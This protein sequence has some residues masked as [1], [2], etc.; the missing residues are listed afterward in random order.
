MR[1]MEMITDERYG[2]AFGEAAHARQTASSLRSALASCAPWVLRRASSE[3]SQLCLATNGRARPQ[4]FLC[5]F[6]RNNETPAAQLPTPVGNCEEGAI[7][8]R[9]DGGAKPGRGRGQ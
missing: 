9:S 6:I 1:K 8:E 3:S 4:Y 2:I 5:V 7:G